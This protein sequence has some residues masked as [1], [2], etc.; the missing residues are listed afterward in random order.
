[1][2]TQWTVPPST[3]EAIEKAQKNGHLC[4][5]NTGRPIS[6]IDSSH[7]R[8]FLL[9]AISVVVAPI[10]EYQQQLLFHTQLDIESRNKSD[11]KH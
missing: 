10:F 4:F 2:K 11:S 1:M 5:I 3:I 7:Y 8:S 6:T 9:M